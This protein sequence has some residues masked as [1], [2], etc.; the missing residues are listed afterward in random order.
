MVEAGQLFRQKFR[1]TNNEEYNNYAEEIYLLAV[2]RGN[3]E[4]MVY[5]ST[6][7]Y[8][9]YAKGVDVDVNHYKHLS[10]MYAAYKIGVKNK[11]LIDNVNLFVNSYI[12]KND[13]DFKKMLDK[14]T[15]KCISNN[16]KNC[17]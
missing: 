4:A 12:K 3:T 6:M 9:K 14:Q 17:F 5:L 16:F 15:D 7:Y 2:E 1:S 11:D 8:E 10:W 13:E